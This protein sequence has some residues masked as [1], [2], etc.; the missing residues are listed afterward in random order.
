MEIQYNN[1]LRKIRANSS[2][3]EK[4]YSQRL[5]DHDWQYFDEQDSSGAIPAKVAEKSFA[6]TPE[7]TPAPAETVTEKVKVLDE[8]HR[9]GHEQF[10]KTNSD[11]VTLKGGAEI[12][13]KVSTVPTWEIQ[14]L[15]NEEMKSKFFEQHSVLG[16]SKFESEDHQ[17][18]V[19]FVNDEDIMSSI[20]QEI[21]HQ[22][23]S[24]F[25]DDEVAILFQRMI[26]AMKLEKKKY[27][28][29]SLLLDTDEAQELVLNEIYQRNPKYIVTLGGYVTSHL[30]KT[31]ERL[32]Q[33]RGRFHKVA[34][35][36]GA[37][38]KSFEL[39]PLFSPNYLN[40]APNSK[41]LAWEDMQKLM[42]KLA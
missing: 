29:S 2:S 3:L 32:A 21:D 6:K 15:S 20:N 9:F 14:A 18:D 5:F 38:Q 7:D 23:L 33:L 8:L 40:E 30:L 12:H 41:R 13:K 34:I 24:V 10:E 36:M 26:F 31:K 4:P 1:A 22:K 37:E 27:S 35:E 16:S 39:L 11:K 25:Y 17:L 28:I 19:L 42:E